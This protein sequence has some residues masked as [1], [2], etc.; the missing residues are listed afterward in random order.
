MHE[1]TPLLDQQ[2]LQQAEALNFMAW[3][4]QIGAEQVPVQASPDVQVNQPELVPPASIIEQFGDRIVTA[5]GVTGTL[6]EL[7]EKCP[8]PKELRTFEGDQRF[9]A[10]ILE[11]NGIAIPEAFAH[12][13]SEPP[14]QKAEVAE[15]EKHK[16]STSKLEIDKVATQ[17][18]AAEQSMTASSRAL[19]TAAD[20][21]L[22]GPE[23]ESKLTSQDG[24]EAESS[25]KSKTV[26]EAPVTTG[27][28]PDLN[29]LANETVDSLDTPRLP[30]VAILRKRLL[31]LDPSTFKSNKAAAVNMAEHS[32]GDTLATSLVTQVEIPQANETSYEEQ[33]V[34]LYLEAANEVTANGDMGTQSV[35]ISDE[36]I[37]DFLGTS[38]TASEGTELVGDSYDL[39]AMPDTLA[40][41]TL[42]TLSYISD[43]ETIGV[44]QDERL[45]V[46]TALPVEVAVAY[47]KM[48]EELEPE[49]AEQLTNLVEKMSR[50]AQRLQVLEAKQQIE[51]EEA[52]QI[53]KV[54]EVYYDQLLHALIGPGAIDPEAR[55]I[56]IAKIR[57]NIF[58]RT[59]AQTF[60]IPMEGT[61]EFDRDLIKQ[62]LMSQG[63]QQPA[64]RKP[65][66]LARI[67]AMLGIRHDLQD[68]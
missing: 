56:F 37:A 42:N 58:H 24:L 34:E 48:I 68:A 21:K 8:Y 36:M 38:I 26:E 50:V 44:S 6:T 35:D 62:A 10:K 14:K 65:I 29:E 66:N 4:Q 57:T 63:R 27:G 1:N 22:L 28:G 20:A 30:N 18:V 67:F 12:L 13:R 64:N 51:S 41:H 2:D 49:A 15:A 9:G 33:M 19:E 52:Q 47:Q 61:R 3:Q 23:T 59:I 17:S 7:T 40:E 31:D 43:G 45:F 16:E 39:P 46:L 54:L 32:E 5:F 53:I 60:D 55:R 25:E 11:K